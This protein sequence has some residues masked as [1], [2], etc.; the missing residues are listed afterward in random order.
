M[1]DNKELTLDEL[2]AKEAET[3]SPEIQCKLGEYYQKNNN[4]EEAFKWY[5]LAAE[6]GY[7]NAQ[8][9][10]GLIYY[11]GEGVDT[12]YEKANELLTL[13]AQQNWCFEDVLTKVQI[14]IADH[15]FDEA[16]EDDD[17]KFN[18]ALKYYLLVANYENDYTDYAQNRI[19]RIYDLQG[20]STEAVKWF[21]LATNLNNKTAWFNLG[22]SYYNGDGINQDMKEANN[23]FEAAYNHG[24]D[25]DSIVNFYLNSTY[26]PDKYSFEWLKK[27]AE[28]GS[29]DVFP[30]LINIYFGDYDFL[31][32]V[33]RVEEAYKYLSIGIENGLDKEEFLFSWD[34]DFY[35]FYFEFVDYDDENWAEDDCIKYYIQ[36]CAK[37][38]YDEFSIGRYFEEHGYTDDMILWYTLAAKRGNANAQFILGTIYDSGIEV[39]NDTKKAAEYFMMAA[40]QG[41]A[42]AQYE[43]GYCYKIGRGV[44]ENKEKAIEWFSRAAKAGIDDAKEELEELKKKG[45]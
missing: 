22:V 19:G 2:L 1:A 38:G 15:Y 3:H 5:S 18:E 27:G 17:A 40:E 21:K 33:N 28:Q 29:T 10:L 36:L 44:E 7:P 20:N 24:M 45:K 30:Y 23:C 34:Y 9:N 8:Y 42:E 41:L 4:S 35:S 13:A 43:L 25:L 6:K 16:E 14:G 31:K 37:F 39:E 11:N 26:D 32:D 12:N